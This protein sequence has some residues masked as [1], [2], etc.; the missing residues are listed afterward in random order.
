M[1]KA[2]SGLTF[3]KLNKSVDLTKKWPAMF[4]PWEILHHGMF[5]DRKIGGKGK[6]I[7]SFVFVLKTK[8][9]CD[10]HRG[11]CEGTFPVC[12]VFSS[13]LQIQSGRT[14]VIFMKREIS[15]LSLL[16]FENRD[17][18]SKFECS[19]PFLWDIFGG[20][21]RIS[22]LEGGCDGC[23]I[24]GRFGP[25]SKDLK[26]VG[27]IRSVNQLVIHIAVWNQVVGGIW[28][29]WPVLQRTLR[30][31]TEW[32]GHSVGWRSVRFHYNI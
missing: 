27:L 20:H 4:K 12:S 5:F 10:I 21:V 23:G 32:P 30:C 28:L 2:E 26:G 8:I 9:L 1:P 15:I 3:G 14:L 18:V 31:Q 7:F 22:Q 11:K 29:Y 13:Q 24:Q 17:K 25:E 16:I 6:T 19:W